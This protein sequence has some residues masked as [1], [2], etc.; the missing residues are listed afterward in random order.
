MQRTINELTIIKNKTMNKS[1]TL[2]ISTLMIFAISC[3][4]RN[5]KK[6]KP[7]RLALE[8][9]AFGGS[10]DNIKY[11]NAIQFKAANYYNDSLLSTPFDSV[12][13][14]IEI[15]STKLPKEYVQIFTSC[16]KGDSVIT[17]TPVDSLLKFTQLPPYAVPKKGNYVGYHFK[18]VDVITNPTRVTMLKEQSMNSM[19]KIDSMN[20]MKQK[21]IDDKVLSDYLAK[22][23][24]KATKTAKGTYVEI[25]NP[26]TGEQVD[27]GKAI[28]VDYKGMTLEGKVFDQ[29]YD[30]SGK[31]VK[32][33]TFVVDQRGPIEGWSDGLKLFKNG[34][35]GKLFIPSYLAYGSRGAGADIKPNTSIMFDV[36]IKDVQTREQYMQKMQE[37]RKGMQ[38]AMKSRQQ[39]MKKD[40]ARA[41]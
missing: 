29:S 4:D 27:S 2:A 37:K 10:G 1:I 12:S 8:Y 11:G 17:R 14:V 24:I 13:Q 34:G 25:D 9:K 26:G 21:V 6:V 5:F 33:Y 35:N 39:Q 22:N 32:P 28:T 15:D 19:K 41:K 30:S 16:K 23:N 36:A 40:S 18:I 3:Q 38:D 20:T 7:A 31:S